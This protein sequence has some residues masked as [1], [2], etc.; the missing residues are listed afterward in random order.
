MRTERRLQGMEGAVRRSP[1]EIYCL[2]QQ[3]AGEAAEL[4]VE[5]SRH[6]IL[7]ASSD[8]ECDLREHVF[9]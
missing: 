1:S 8:A 6:R 5:R 2:H 7:C 3:T 9:S 4:P